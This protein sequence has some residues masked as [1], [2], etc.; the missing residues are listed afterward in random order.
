MFPLALAIPHDLSSPARTAARRA[1]VRACLVRATTSKFVMA[2]R[3]AGHPGDASTALS[4]HR[5]N[6]LT[7]QPHELAPTGPALRRAITML[8]VVVACNS[9]G[10]D[11]K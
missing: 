3:S 4:G 9:A 2:R 5:E 8:L 6:F 7:R 11:S 10:H 1:A